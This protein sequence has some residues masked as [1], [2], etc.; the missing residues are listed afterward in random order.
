MSCPE[1]ILS[2]VEELTLSLAKAAQEEGLKAWDEFEL[3]HLPDL[4]SHSVAMTQAGVGG[5]D[6]RRILKRLKATLR[7]QGS[8][9]RC[10]AVECLAADLLDYRL[11]PKSIQEIFCFLRAFE[12]REP[13]ATED[14]IRQLLSLLTKAH[15]EGL[16]ALDEDLESAQGLCFRFLLRA[17]VEGFSRKVFIRILKTARVLQASRD[18]Y[19]QEFELLEESFRAL[20]G[21]WSG[22]Q[23]E[24]VLKGIAGRPVDNSLPENEMPIDTFRTRFFPIHYGLSA[25]LGQETPW[26]VRKAFEGLSVVV[27][28]RALTGLPESVGREVLQLLPRYRIAAIVKQQR[29]VFPPSELEK[30]QK[31]QQTAY[32]ALGGSE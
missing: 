11:N 3:S 5:K 10:L 22:L 2:R 6:R 26:I 17:V 4:I 12:G 13:V 25:R 8:D 9:R 32:R 30:I 27:A 18:S 1:E 20:T 31:A 21:D 15:N 16:L 23:T 19:A 28:A 14:W 7:S 29:W 24:F